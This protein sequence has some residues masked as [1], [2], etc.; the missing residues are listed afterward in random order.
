MKRV[1][2]ASFPSSLV[3]IIELTGQ[4]CLGP[5]AA[6]MP[7]VLSV[8]LAAKEPADQAPGGALPGPPPQ[9]LP[10]WPSSALVLGVPGCSPH[11]TPRGPPLLRLQGRQDVSAKPS[12]LRQGVRWGG[13]GSC[14]VRPGPWFPPEGIVKV[15]PIWKV[16]FPIMFSFEN[17]S[18]Q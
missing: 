2:G 5:G 15:L 1:T 9:Q 3:Q 14:G 7:T 13:G 4:A 8:L 16:F 18:G 6:K 12:L 10:A 17:S 11:P